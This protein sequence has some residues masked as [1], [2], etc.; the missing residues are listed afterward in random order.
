[1]H[2]HGQWNPIQRFCRHCEQFRCVF[3][4]VFLSAD[5]RD[6]LE[7]KNWCWSD[8]RLPETGRRSTSEKNDVWVWC[9]CVLAWTKFPSDQKTDCIIRKM[10]TFIEHSISKTACNIS[11]CTIFSSFFLYLFSRLLV[12]MSMSFFKKWE[13]RNRKKIGS[14]NFQLCWSREVCAS[15]KWLSNIQ[16]RWTAKWSCR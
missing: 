9:V 7:Q 6:S 2:R 16:L 14:K 15:R 8:V 5:S 3:L 4:F 1:M 12:P 10:K 13:K 11:G